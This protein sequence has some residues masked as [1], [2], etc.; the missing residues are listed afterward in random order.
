MA[1]SLIAHQINDDGFQYKSI[2]LRNAYDVSLLSK[3]A[4]LQT[5]LEKFIKLK[6]P[7]NCFLASSYQVFNA[8]KSLKYTTTPA[9]EKYL[10]KFNGLLD[11][12]FL[13]KKFDAKT[14]KKL[15]IKKRIG[16]IYKSI[17]DKDVRNWI[18]KRTTD[19]KWYSEKLVQIGLKKSKP[20]V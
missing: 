6:K 19:K 14:A 11:N 18:I 7:L 20:N 4:N 10:K 9:T 3:K 1:L 2:V 5:S 12:S 13:R 16:L 17:F 8:P 15:F